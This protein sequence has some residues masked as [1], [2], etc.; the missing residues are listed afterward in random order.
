MSHAKQYEDVI[1]EVRGLL[2]E[3][4]GWAKKYARYPKSILRNEPFI[5]EMCKHFRRWT[6]LELYLTT[7]SAQNA[8]STATFD[9]RYL[10]QPV[11]ALSCGQ[12]ITLRIA[13]GIA[14]DNKGSFKCPA[15]PAKF[16]WVGPEATKFRKHF[17][18]DVSPDLKGKEPERRIESMLLSEFS[19]KVGPRKLLRGIQ[20]IKIAKGRYPMPSAIS[21]S[22]ASKGIIGYVGDQVNQSH[23]DI[24][25]R[26]GRGPN[27]N[28]CIIE[29]K[30]ENKPSEPAS[31]VIKQALAYAVFIRELLRSNAGADWREVFGFRSR[32]P[33]KLTLYAAC[34]MPDIGDADTPFAGTELRIDEDT[35]QMHYISFEEKDN[36]I[37]KIRTSLPTIP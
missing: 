25:A 6:P 33:D 3:N 2:T 16:P 21:A 35:I 23:I 29:V 32:V 17:R 27:T 10:G 14:S 36:K 31:A 12:E 8:R 11:A 24:L 22:K 30:D 1:K 13:P 9:L 26:V 19:K 20:P 34:A 37:T 5:S 4:D 7:T 28:L 18:W 15:M